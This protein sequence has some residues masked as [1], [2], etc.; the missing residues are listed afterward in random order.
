MVRFVVFFLLLLL[1]LLIQQKCTVKKIVS[2]FYR[3]RKRRSSQMY[4]RLSKMTIFR[5]AACCCFFRVV[6]RCFTFTKQGTRI[7]RSDDKNGNNNTISFHFIRNS[8]QDENQNRNHTH[9]KLIHTK[10]PNSG[11]HELSLD[12][13]VANIPIFQRNIIFLLC[14]SQTMHTGRLIRAAIV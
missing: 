11:E 8:V 14:F 13:K 7:L 4:I 10:S 6:L 1:L 5:F 12:K 3:I 9:S 2:T